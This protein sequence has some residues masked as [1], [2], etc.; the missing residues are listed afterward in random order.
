MIKVPATLA[1]LEALTELAA[2]G[3]P[4]NVTLIFTQR[5][6]EAARDAIWRGAQRRDSLEHFKSVYSIFISRVDVYTAKQI[7]ELSPE[8]QGQV[9]IVN[10]KLMWRA[11]REFWRH[12]ACPL[13]QEIV[14]AS[15][16]V[17]TK[18]DPPWKYVAALAGGDIQ[19]N[20]PDTNEAAQNSG[21]AFSSRLSELP[22]ETVLEE[23]ATK[24]DQQK[25]E[26]VLMAEGIAKFAEPQKGL[27]ALIAERRAELA[28][29]R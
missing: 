13:S 4:L 28:G 8:A 20:P 10:A 12:K 16:G 2:S 1:G 17:K 23:I 21:Q 22:P 29:S 5:Q 9:G 3:V 14:F 18:S 15:T 27:L 26:E 25:L 7:P 6:Y 11:N 24:V 19:T